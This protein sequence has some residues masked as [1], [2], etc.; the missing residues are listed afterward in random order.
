MNAKI[1]LVGILILMTLL[2]QACSQ[3]NEAP[4]YAARI[5]DAAQLEKASAGIMNLDEKNLIALVPP[6]SGFF[7]SGCPNCKGGAQDKS[8]YWDLALGEKVQ[9]RYCK[10]QF[11]NEQY[12]DDRRLEVSTPNGGKQIFKYHEAPDG[13]KY[14]FE[15]RRWYEQRLLLEKAAYNLAQ[16]YRRDPVKH[17]NA[18]QRAAGILK[19][20]AAVYPGYVVHF[21]YPGQPKQFRPSNSVAGFEELPDGPYRLTKWSWW[22]YMDISQEL[23]LAYDQLSGSPLLQFADR[24]HIEH[25]LFGAMID[26]VDNYKHIPST[27]MHPTMWETQA[28]A[29][30]VLERPGLANRVLGG[31]RAMV[32]QQFTADGFWIQPTVSYHLQT[33]AGLRLVLAALYPDLKGAAFDEFL[34][35]EYPDLARALNAEKVFH[36]PNG[37]YAAI[38]D[39]WAYEKYAPPIQKSHPHLMPHM[40][41]GVLGFGEGDKQLQAHLDFTGRFGH[42][43]YGSLNL[44]LFGAG[45]EQISD[46][47]YTHSIARPWTLST[48]AHNTVVVDGET[49]VAAGE[50]PN[51]VRGDLQ[52]FETTD[53]SFQAMEVA[54]PAAYSPKTT[55]YRRALIAVQTPDGTQYV[56]DIFNVAGGKTHDWILHGSADNDQKLTLS[57]G[58]QSS[59]K[60]QPRNSLLPAGFDF[61]IPSTEH[62]VGWIWNGPWAYGNFRNIKETRNTQTIKATFANTAEPSRGLQSWIMGGIDSTFFTTR[63]WA[64]R[65]AKENE[66]EL[67]KHMRSSLIVRREGGASRFV[68][69]HVPFEGAPGVRTVTQLPWPAGGVLLKIESPKA[70]DYV[71]YQSEAKL[72]TGTLANQKLV[73]DGRVAL[74][75]I[76]GSRTTL[77]CLGKSSLTLGSQVVKGQ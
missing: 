75:R 26:F 1:K 33:T 45:K 69:V 60:M 61:R 74:I 63:S 71:L 22:A 72:Q 53:L 55:D 64:V 67:N 48:A 66:L 47:G 35:R 76:E 32:A 51:Y 8:L 19:R 23:V 31:V 7:W 38:S 62:E 39:T 73:F 57:D 65:G 17:A 68:A 11:P 59:L 12:P 70:T 14:W 18:G 25:D 34:H 49:Q 10:M 20:F 4:I 9:C 30:R 54:A 56:V 2:P 6:Q 28:I 58:G 27:N 50:A 52:F 5:T 16:L 37:H 43:H 46:I 3:P 21:D 42:Q 13:T 15:A 44:L 29:A 24:K 36:L 77:K 41:Y 40:G